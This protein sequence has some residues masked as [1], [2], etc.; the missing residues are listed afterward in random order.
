MMPCTGCKHLR[1]G[2]RGYCARHDDQ[3]QDCYVTD[4]TVNKTRMVPFLR[5]TTESMRAVGGECGPERKL[6][7]PNF[8]RRLAA[9]LR[10]GRR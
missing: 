5:P 1:V 7:E 10:S 6:F 3:F 4:P 2:R 8:W 9:R